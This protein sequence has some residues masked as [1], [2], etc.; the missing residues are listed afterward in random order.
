MQ[1]SD[2]MKRGLIVAGVCAVLLVA[3]FVMSAVESSLSSEVAAKQAELTAIKNKT[4]TMSASRVSTSDLAGLSAE[5]LDAD[6]ETIDALCKKMFT[7]D[8]KETYD[9]QR[10]ALAKAYETGGEFA[11]AIEPYM[12]EMAEG[13]SCAYKSQESY[14][15]GAVKGERTY[16]VR[17]HVYVSGTERVVSLGVTVDNDGEVSDLTYYGF[18]E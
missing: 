2:A 3:G 18:D 15:I 7:W 4:Q 9:K 16:L 12:G 11:D 17:A 14:V 8:S 6:A 5:R 13:A 1:I 10:D